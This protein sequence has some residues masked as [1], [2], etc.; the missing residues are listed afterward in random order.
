MT[1]DLKTINYLWYPLIHNSLHKSVGHLDAE[2][3]WHQIIYERNCLERFARNCPAN[4]PFVA[5]EK[6]SSSFCSVPTLLGNF[7]QLLPSWNHSRCHWHFP[8]FAEPER[9]WL[10]HT[11]IDIHYASPEM[12]RKIWKLMKNVSLN[13]RI[14]LKSR[15]KWPWT[16]AAN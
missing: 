6:S 8:G 9:G 11:A 16:V 10:H 15:Q 12:I 7:W 13:I 1:L 5:P 4:T 2:I 14:N 3:V